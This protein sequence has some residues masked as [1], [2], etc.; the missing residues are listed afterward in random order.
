VRDLR[1]CVGIPVLKSEAELRASA[2]R[3]G[4]VSVLHWQYTTPPREAAAVSEI[5]V[6]PPCFP[7]MLDVPMYDVVA[8]SMDDAVATVNSLVERAR[9]MGRRAPHFV[10]VRILCPE[11]QFKPDSA[12][13]VYE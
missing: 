4:L 10:Y 6:K 9:G 3:D 8:A 11:T 5:T 12:E 1:I 2:F 7:R 13:G